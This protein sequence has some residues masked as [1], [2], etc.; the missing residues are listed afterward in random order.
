[1]DDAAR[2]RAYEGASIQPAFASRAELW[3][4]RLLPTALL[5]QCELTAIGTVVESASGSRLPA[6]TRN[7]V[8]STRKLCR[9]S[10]AGDENSDGEVPKNCRVAA[11]TT[12]R[13]VSVDRYRDA[14][15][16]DEGRKGPCVSSSIVGRQ[17][18]ECEH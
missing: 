11:D 1:M 15:T 18:C 17:R 16:R 4:G 5:A 8:P 9:R 3:A 2:R 6:R 10:V 14:A 12:L 7:A 13:R